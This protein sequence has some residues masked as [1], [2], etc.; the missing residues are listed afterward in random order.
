MTD[1]LKNFSFGEMGHLGPKNCAFNS[2]SA[3]KIYFKFCTMKEANKQ[4]RMITIIFKKNCLGH[5]HNSGPAVNFCLIFA[6]RK[7]PIGRCK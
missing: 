6:Q 3:G 1:F 4:M 7:G 2:G 5:R